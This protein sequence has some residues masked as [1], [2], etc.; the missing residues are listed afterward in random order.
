MTK[1][2]TK[3]PNATILD[4]RSVPIPS[5]AR[6]TTP[7]KLDANDVESVLAEIRTRPENRLVSEK[8]I[9]A[10]GMGAIHKAT[11]RALVR[12]VA[13]KVLHNH[14]LGN[15][16]V[17]RMFLREARVN[18]VLDHPNVVPVY[19][20]GEGPGGQLYFT[21]KL[22]EGNALRDVIRALPEGPLETSTLWNLLD[23]V[24]KVMDALAFAHSRGVLHCDVKPAN[25]MVGDFGEVY[26]MDWGI[27]R[28][29]TR[30]AGTLPPP[31]VQGAPPSSEDAAIQT[32]DL[33]I[34]TAS[35][36]SPEQASGNRSALDARSDIFLVGALL[37]E[38]IAR[39][40]PFLAG[41]FDETL[42]RALE[43][44]PEP[45]SQI[46]KEV[47]PELER[48]ITRAMMKSREDRYPSMR[49]LKDDVVRFMRGG[50]EFPKTTFPKGSYVMR[51]GERGDSAYIIATGKCD[52]LKIIDGQVSVMQRL[53]PGDVFGETAILT[54]GTRTAT[55]LCV[56]D[57]TVLV[58]T[59]KVFEAELAQVKP[60]MRSVT[61]TLAQRFRD[62]YA[63]KRVTHVGTVNPAR[64]AK[65]IYMHLTS[66]GD[67]LPGGGFSARWTR[68][69]A[70]IEGQLGTSIAMSI[71]NV[72][73]RYPQ[74]QVDFATDTLRMTD[75]TSLKLAV[76]TA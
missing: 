13:K 9:A 31:S 37:Y 57:T 40:P 22:V 21:M 45:L 16:N 65:Q 47:P 50:A 10:G 34:G 1:P 23:V 2:D 19:D 41:G 26:L 53:G 35:Y 43:C 5:D 8:T 32:N 28:L 63:Q 46:A 27:A 42:Q 71:M 67:P 29:L 68:V 59:R 52:V 11:D 39:K 7:D 6:A 72:V 66:F 49:E 36:M 4:R 33:V 70:E 76:L 20:I 74:I 18:G 3:D 15:Q 14:L 55:I 64:V 48:I 44:A 38:I 12:H 30:S 60:W 56:E 58:V 51:E 24:I 62:L 17:V 54:E 61:T 25:V 69:C 73:A 75:A